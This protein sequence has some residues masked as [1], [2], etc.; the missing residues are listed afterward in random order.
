VAH[1]ELVLGGTL[2]LPQLIARMSS[3]PAAAFSLPEAT[4]RP[5]APADVVV[6]DITTPWTVDPAAFLSKSRNT[7]FAGR[8][9][10]GRAVLT[11]VGGTI[12]HQAAPPTRQ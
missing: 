8:T 2:S 4:L 5:G 1:T 11:L 10:T 12:V 7:P 9:L 6:L 3:A